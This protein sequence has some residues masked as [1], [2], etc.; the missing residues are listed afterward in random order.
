MQRRGNS[1][2]DM[3]NFRVFCG[4]FKREAK[5]S[6]NGPIIEP[7]RL[8]VQ[9]YTL[10]DALA[11]DIRGTL[12]QVADMGIEYVEIAGLGSATVEEWAEIL[13]DLGLKASGSHIMPDV[14]ENDFDAVLHQAKTLNFKYVVVPWAGEAQYGAGWDLF[15]QRLNAIGEKLS[16]E[17][18][19][20]LYHNHDFEF[21][22]TDN[23]KVLYANADPANLGA[24]VDVAWVQ[25]GGHEPAAYVTELGDRVKILH[26][27]DYNAENT[28]RW[29]PAGQGTVD[30][31]G[32]V[33]AAP[34]A[35]FG[36]IELDESPIDPIEA[37]RQSAEYLKGLGLS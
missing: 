3:R 24:E 14:V 1:R 31:A 29:T 36:I 19:E 32:V 18:L 8:S 35:E 9:L 23:L 2:N 28:P 4:Q 25:L 34:R 17:G 7:M 21:K 20:L 27:K 33:A 30:L 10:R 16:Q 6:E 22:G 15:G 26:L 37:V 13:G 12:S 5:V 11:M